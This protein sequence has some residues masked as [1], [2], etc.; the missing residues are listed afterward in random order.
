M[1]FPKLITAGSGWKVAL[2]AFLL[3]A[4]SIFSATATAAAAPA[5]G[6]TAADAKAPVVTVYQ[7]T[8]TAHRK[9]GTAA[10]GPAVIRCTLAVT[11]PLILSPGQTWGPFNTIF[12]TSIGGLARVTCTS[13]VRS[14]NLVALLEWDGMPQL[15]GPPVQ[16]P[17][18][19]QTTAFAADV[20]SSGTWAVGG[21]AFVA[22]PLGYTGPNQ[23][24]GFGPSLLFQPI[25]CV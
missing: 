25:D 2:A 6:V 4:A 21:S 5:S 20:C 14:I 18:A 9:A 7:Q 16:E 19:V 15:P 12:F 13:P 17:G 3:V 10:A 1:K 23:L 11:F 8:T 22:W 24:S